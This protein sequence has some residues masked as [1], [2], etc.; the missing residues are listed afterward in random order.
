MFIVVSTEKDGRVTTTLERK[1]PLV[2]IR[3]FVMSNLRDDWVVSKDLSFCEPVSRNVGLECEFVGRGRSS[4]FLFLQ[5]GAYGVLESVDSGKL[6]NRN[7]TYVCCFVA[8]MNGLLKNHTSSI[9]YAKKKDKKQVISF[10]KDETI[11]RDDVYKSHV[12]SVPTGEPPGSLSR[13][14]AKRKPGQVR[15]ITQ[16]KLLRKGGPSGDVGIC[17]ICHR[18]LALNLL[19]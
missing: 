17:L 18:A 12:V 1:V 5:D 6:A 16:G 2:T 10:K 11:R 4:V 13:P 8:V 3:A 14:P 15:P 7:R 9:E 19:F